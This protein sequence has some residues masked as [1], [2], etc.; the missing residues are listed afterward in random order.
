MHP[1]VTLLVCAA[2]LAAISPVHAADDW[3]G[4]DKTK[5]F[6]VSAAV[7]TISGFYLE[8]KWK[9]F[10]VAMIPGLLKE[11]ADSNDANNHFSSRD[12]VADAL[13][14]A[15]GVHVGH[16]ILSRRGVSY[17]AAF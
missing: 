3:T 6:M 15:V 14:A 10:G 8:N 13:G 1:P 5:H 12:L 4:P 16:W 11:V 9:A 7:G 2:Y 17:H